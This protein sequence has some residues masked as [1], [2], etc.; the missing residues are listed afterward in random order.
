MKLIHKIYN[1]PA[2]VNISMKTIAVSSTN[3]LYFGEGLLSKNAGYC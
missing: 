2:V 3:Q 1:L